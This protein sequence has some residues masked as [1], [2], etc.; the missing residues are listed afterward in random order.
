MTLTSGA[1][2]RL[3]NGVQV[4]AH[5]GHLP[6]ERWRLV[7]PWACW[8]I[9]ES[10]GDIVTLTTDRRGKPSTRATGWRVGDLRE[11]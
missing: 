9:L 11:G 5:P 2:V 3:P 4:T 6:G 8:A 7:H 10:S 1:S